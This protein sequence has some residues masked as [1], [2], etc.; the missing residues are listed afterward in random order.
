MV[1]LIS[2]PLQSLENA[3]VI[4]VENSAKAAPQEILTATQSIDEL[5]NANS[6]KMEPQLIHYLKRRS[7]S[8][9]LAHLRQA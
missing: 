2:D 3:L 6:D 9:A 5:L 4:I 1:Q 7:Y 8:K